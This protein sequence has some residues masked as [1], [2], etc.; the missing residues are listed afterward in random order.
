MSGSVIQLAAKGAQDAYITSSNGISMFRMK[1]A[2][3]KNFAQAPKLIK[4]LSVKD[5]T[6]V[7]PSYGDLINGLW[8]EGDDLIT[9]FTGCT[10]HLYVGGTKID[11][12]SFDYMADVWQNY[13]AETYT[14]S[15]EINN[16]TSTSNTKFLPLHFY[17]CDHDMFLPLVALQYHQVEIRIDFEDTTQ[18]LNA[19]IYGNYVFLD[20]DERKFFVNTT[21]DFIITQVQKQTYDSSDNLDISFFNHPVKS[22]F[23]GHPSKSGI[24]VHDKFTFASADIYL[25]STALV[26]NMSPVYFHT[27]QNYMHS[28]FGISQFDENENSPFYTRYFAFHFCKNA[29][30]YTPNG[31]C[32]FSRL[33]DV[34]INLRNVQRGINRTGEKITVYAVNYNILKVSK[35]MAG[36]LF[37]N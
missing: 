13:L 37:G 14:K 9:K 16:A 2:R 20:T 5:S 3:H 19:K 4:A 26:E 8:I 32:N 28:K 29:S 15:Q 11:S 7:I 34:K 22:I 17:F 1:Y 6:I 33:D 10:F 12:Q 30:S 27:V 36:I 31:T 23:F 35:G 18:D 24:L 21:H 25:N